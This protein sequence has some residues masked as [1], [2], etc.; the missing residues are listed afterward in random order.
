MGAATLC[1]ALR[2]ALGFDVPATLLARADEEI[3]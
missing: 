2:K 1:A 3:E